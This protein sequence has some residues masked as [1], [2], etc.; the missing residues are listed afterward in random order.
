M[1]PAFL[2]QLESSAEEPSLPG[3]AVAD[4]SPLEHGGKQR[5]PASLTRSAAKD[6]AALASDHGLSRL[7]SRGRCIYLT[8]GG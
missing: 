1:S 3:K 6:A 7:G 2:P 8:L 4:A 5:I